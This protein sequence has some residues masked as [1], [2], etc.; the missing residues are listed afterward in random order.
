MPAHRHA[1]RTHKQGGCGLP[2]RRHPGPRAPGSEVALRPGR[3]R[4]A[5][6]CPWRGANGD[7]PPPADVPLPRQR[8]T[9]ARPTTAAAPAHLSPAW[10]GRRRRKRSSVRSAS[11]PPAAAMVSNSPLG[12]FLRGGHGARHAPSHPEARRPS[13]ANGRPHC[14]PGRAVSTLEK[15]RDGVRHS[16]GQ[17]AQPAGQLAA[18]TVPLQPTDG[19]RRPPR[20]LPLGRIGA[21]SAVRLCFSSPSGGGL[22]GAFVQI[23]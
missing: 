23:A 13:R 20:L 22:A 16:T 1:S 2:S 4:T 10:S 18:G 15:R 12:A 3:L 11:P 7:A 17:R 19:Q 5:Q 6:P 9:P 21:A 8:S 14:K